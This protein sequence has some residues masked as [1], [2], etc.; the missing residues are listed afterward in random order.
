MLSNRD[1]RERM[2]HR[3]NGRKREAFAFHHPAIN[4]KCLVAEM[5]RLGQVLWGK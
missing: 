5:V 2:E 1:R 3:W 4:V